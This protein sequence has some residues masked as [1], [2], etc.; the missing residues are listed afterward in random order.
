MSLVEPPRAR[1]RQA[2]E[3]TKQQILEAAEAFLA[4]RPFRDLS[5]DELMAGTGHSRTVFYRHFDDL[6]DLALNVLQAVGAELY[7]VGQKWSEAVERLPAHDV[8]LAAVVDFFVDHGRLIRAISE[9]SHHDPEIERVYAATL[10]NFIAMTEAAIDQLRE[11]GEHLEPIDS[12]E[13]ARGL[14]YLN[15][16]YLL[17]SF[18]REP[19]ADRDRV[20]RTLLAIWQRSIFGHDLETD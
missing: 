2:R 17:E 14:T 11:R 15:E 3:E 20:L 7:T 10:D 18:G 1:R 13:L 12:H 5:V 9:A 19:V 16:R 4:E 8:G 6:G